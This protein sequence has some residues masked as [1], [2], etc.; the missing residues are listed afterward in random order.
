MASPSQGEKGRKAALLAL[1]V[2]IKSVDVAK[3]ACSGIPPAHIA[4]TAA[5][6]LL[7]LIKVCSLLFY[8]GGLPIHVC[9]G[10]RG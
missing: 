6:E 2:V 9:S 8:R 10:L 4:L 5:S 1:N 7:T 3:A